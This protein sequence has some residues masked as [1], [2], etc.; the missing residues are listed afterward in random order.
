MS[1]RKVP[2]VAARSWV[3][4]SMTPVKASV[5][6]KTNAT[7]L[8]PYATR[9]QYEHRSCAKEAPY[10]VVRP[11]YFVEAQSCSFPPEHD[12]LCLTRA[13]G[14][15]GSPGVRTFGGAF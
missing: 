4:D 5:F 9:R 13:N 12:R 8:T 3:P 15:A 7:S 1:L 2:H 6:K 10:E 14:R 11:P